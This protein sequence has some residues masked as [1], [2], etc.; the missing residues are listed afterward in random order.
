MAIS[1]LTCT[2]K[3][4]FAIITGLIILHVASDAQYNIYKDKY[5]YRT[6]T[7]Q[8]GDPYKPSQMIISSALIPG[9]GQLIEGESIRGLAFLGG[10]IALAVFKTR[11]IWRPDVSFTTS[12]AIRNSVLIGQIGLRVWSGINASRI[13]KV[14]DLAF[15]DKY[16]SAVN[17]KILPYSDIL[18]YYR[19]CK[20]KPVGITLLLSF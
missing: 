4:I 15:R 10:S 3:R 14:N 5:D 18:D 2:M 1:R 7:Y 19:F 12:N 9:L 13:A 6:F 17:L 16:N 8:M 20:T 11:L